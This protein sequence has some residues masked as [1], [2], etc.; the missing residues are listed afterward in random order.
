MHIVIS[1]KL[2]G[3]LSLLDL[4][5]L[6]LLDADISSYKFLILLNAGFKQI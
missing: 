6:I 5:W 1:V 4:K 3:H 2:L